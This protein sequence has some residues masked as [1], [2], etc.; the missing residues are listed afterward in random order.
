[1]SGKVTDGKSRS[2][3]KRMKYD[4]ELA[5]AAR[6]T[7]KPTQAPEFQLRSIAPTP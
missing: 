2:A 4:G 5:M 1:M 7:T 6:T 3:A